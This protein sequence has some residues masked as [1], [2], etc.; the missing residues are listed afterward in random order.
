M[1][2]YTNGDSHLAATYQHP[3]S[4]ESIMFQPEVSFAGL[5]AKKHNLDYINES[6]AGCSNNR[7]I[8]TSKEF[9]RDKDPENTIVLIGWSTVER[10][11]WYADGVWHQI[12]G[13]PLYQ[14]NF[15]E[16]VLPP[17]FDKIRWHDKSAEWITLSMMWSNYTNRLLNDHKETGNIIFQS[18]TLEFQYYFKEFSD[19]LTKRNFKHMFLHLHEVFNVN[20][21]F[22]NNWN[23]DAWLFNDPYD[24]SIAF[25][26]KSV[27]LGHKSDKWQH[28]GPEAHKDYANYIEQEFINKLLK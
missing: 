5:L 10:T 7:I 12:C 3:N 4:E 17:N 8:R 11:E 14:Y 20:E 18:R 19:W 21:F 16:S 2:L 27:A 22:K 24:P 28:F 26:R 6:V 9:L 15:R 13:E 25:T 1:L 23:N